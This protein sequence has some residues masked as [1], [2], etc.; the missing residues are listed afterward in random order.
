MLTRI[1]TAFILVQQLQNQHWRG[2]FKKNSTNPFDFLQ[3]SRQTSQSSPGFRSRTRLKLLEAGIEL[4]TQLVD[5]GL[6]FAL[7]RRHS[8]YVNALSVNL[9]VRLVEG[10]YFRCQNVISVDLN[11]SISTR[12]NYDI[13]VAAS[14]HHKIAILHH[15]TRAEI[16]FL[17]DMRIQ[18]WNLLW[19]IRIVVVIDIELESGHKD[20][21]Q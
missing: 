9:S 6:N 17:K 19:I 10:R 3:P 13:F 14:Y 5:L 8:L 7:K 11:L 18:V 20:T 4:A 2:R 1:R 21:D 15:Q 12:S 16:K